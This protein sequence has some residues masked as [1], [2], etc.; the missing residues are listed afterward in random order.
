[1]NYGREVELTAE[2]LRQ[3]PQ[4]RLEPVG[5]ALYALL[6][7]MTDRPVPRIGPQGWGDQLAVIARDV[8][9]YRQDALVPALRDLRRSLDIVPG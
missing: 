2:R 1:M 8:P 9:A 7:R 5:P 4:V 6:S 3:L